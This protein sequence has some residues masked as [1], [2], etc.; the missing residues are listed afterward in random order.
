MQIV[1]F[2]LAR[3]PD[4]RTQ[5]AS[6]LHRDS[7][8]TVCRRGRAASPRPF[9]PSSSDARCAERATTERRFIHRRLSPFVHACRP[10]SPASSGPSEVHRRSHSCPFAGAR[11]AGQG[12]AAPKGSLD[13]R[14]PSRI[15][16]QGATGQV[17]VSLTDGRMSKCLGTRGKSSRR[18]PADASA[19][20]HKRGK[21]TCAVMTRRR[22][23]GLAFPDG[24]RPG[25]RHP[26]PH[27]EP[28]RERP[29]GARGTRSSRRAG[30]GHA[31]VP[32]AF[33]RRRGRGGTT[34]SRGPATRH[35]KRAPR[36]ARISGP[37]APQ[38]VT[39]S[40]TPGTVA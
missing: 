25:R 29:L 12:R 38:M 31:T 23:A 6:K 10:R 32:S 19:G 8:D 4:G 27:R 1:V 20:R 3:G 30:V 14:R 37:T 15:M 2:T 39:P 7:A 17:S 33:T 11:G 5:L 9:T 13:A 22:R 24:Q 36:R 18:P 35:E 40:P 28:W 16:K 26:Q 34:G 21:R